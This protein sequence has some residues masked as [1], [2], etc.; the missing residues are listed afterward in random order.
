M[1]FY[2]DESGHTGPNLFDPNQPVLYYGVLSAKTNLDVRAEDEVRRAR[3]TLG[4][5]RLHAAEMGMGGLVTIS[6]HLAAVQRKCEPRFDLYR[7]AKPDHA[8]IAFFDQVFDQGINP[9]VTWTGYWT[10][11]RY[12]LL[13]KVASLFADDLAERAWAA[14]VNLNNQ[15]AERELVA[16]CRALLSSLD[17]ISDE[18]SR[19]VIGDALNWAIQH[20]GEL[21]Y[22][23]QSPREILTV[24]PNLIG[25]QLVMQG[26]A[27]RLDKVKSVASITVDQQSQFNRAQRTL[28]E[29]YAE[30]RNLPW[31][32]GPGMPQMDLRSVPTTPITFRSGRDS[33]GLELVDCY[34]WVF[35]R[36]LEGREI[37][38]ELHS[39][40]RPQLQR[41][42]TND[43]SLSSLNERWS[44]WLAEL[45]ELDEAQLERAREITRVDE[46]RRLRAVH[47][48]AAS[49]H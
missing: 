47:A 12:V 8:I 34:L 38:D 11:L 31:Y 21:R 25:F 24:T 16:I 29:F 4:V 18:R 45:P 9:A 17:R 28:A 44:R 33:I 46:A 1:Y 27:Y 10:P 6:R 30:H 36:L 41:G 42:R 26:I 49:G 43:V 39:I 2:V 15:E 3:K 19:Q 48:S 20:V 14:R 37:P 32:L 40:I 13:L 23:C 22:N 7:I 5:D 35:K